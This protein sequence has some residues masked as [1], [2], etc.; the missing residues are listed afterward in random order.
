M[1]WACEAAVELCVVSCRESGECLRARYRHIFNAI[2]NNWGWHQLIK[3]EEL[4]DPKNGLYDEEEDAV[5]FKVEIVAEEPYGMAYVCFY[6]ICSRLTSIFKD[7]GLDK[8][9]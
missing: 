2:Q 4:M 3:F 8:F 9:F 6:V 5:T 7:C 1:T